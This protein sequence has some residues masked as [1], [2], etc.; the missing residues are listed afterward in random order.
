MGTTPIFSFT[1]N[2]AVLSSTTWMRCTPGIQEHIDSKSRMNFHS[3][4]GGALTVNVASRL[5]IQDSCGLDRWC[6]AF[7]GRR[8]TWIAGQA[9]NDNPPVQARNDNPPVQARNDN[10]PVQARNDSPAGQ[11]R[12]D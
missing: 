8:K 3:S 5:G 10:P 9:R 11:A 7:K 12:N 6:H 1:V 4:P 2:S